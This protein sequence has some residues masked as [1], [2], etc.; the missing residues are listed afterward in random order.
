M[1]APIVAGL[2]AG[3]VSILGSV[4]SGLMNRKTSSDQMQE[5]NFL[6]QA[7]IDRMNQYN[8]PLA[9]MER[10]ASAGLNPNLV[11]SGNV[12]GNQSSSTPSVNIPNSKYWNFEGVGDEV[13]QSMNQTKLANSNSEKATA[14]AQLSQARYLNELFDLNKK[15]ALFDT[16]IAQAIANLRK[17]NQSIT[18]GETRIE[19][20]TEE[21]NNLKINRNYLQEQIEL[22]HWKARNEKLYV[23]Q[24]LQ[25]RARNLASDTELNAVQKRVAETVANLNEKKLE[26]LDQQL[27]DLAFT[28]GEHALSYKLAYMMDQFG[29]TGMKPKDFID[30]LMKLVHEAS[31]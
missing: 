24:V 25:E 15:E 14:D 22:T 2:I 1:P 11:Y 18:E 23:P 27:L 28:T 12:T 9:Q 10:L 3:A 31:K 5:Q 19:K 29:V 7:N 6:N 13:I 4:V 17:T 26:Y 16:D 20:M 30:F 8:S 21:I